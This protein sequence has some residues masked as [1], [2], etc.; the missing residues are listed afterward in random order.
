M[1]VLTLRAARP[2][3]RPSIPLRCQLRNSVNVLSTL[4]ASARRAAHRTS[5]RC[6][7]SPEAPASGTEPPAS[8]TE[9]TAEE[10]QG[11][12]RLG[13]R[14]VALYIGYEGSG[15]KG[16]P[17]ACRLGRDGPS[18]KEMEQC[19]PNNPCLH[20]QAVLHC[21]AG[22]QMNRH[23]APDAT[24]EDKLE[25]AIF[26]AGGILE[27]NLGALDKLRWSRSSRTDKSV[28][29]LSTVGGQEGH[30]GCFGRAYATQP[31]Q[32]QQQR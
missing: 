17:A 19:L 29:S 14:K 32:Q 20:R 6:V 25:Q 23:S 13:K 15:Y 27:S 9:A 18:A 3:I 1:G 22:L 7:H 4:S 28:H 31:R 16:A 2:L 24:I 5:V 26:K 8:S 11:K 21:H 10:Q 12:S 30:A